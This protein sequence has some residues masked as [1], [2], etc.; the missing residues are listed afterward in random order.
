MPYTSGRFVAEYN[1]HYLDRSNERSLASIYV[2]EDMVL[3]DA[4]G[5]GAPDNADLIAWNVALASITDGAVEK[6][7]LNQSLRNTPASGA[8]RREQKYTFYYTD[9]ITGKKNHFEVPCRDGAIETPPNTDLYDLTVA[10]WVAVKTAFQTA[11]RS[12]V[13]NTVTLRY[14]ELTGKNN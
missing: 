7:S 1:V 8:G 5:D 9:D 13:G 3:V 10:P 12:D 2:D 11:A 4:A 14:V 6:Y